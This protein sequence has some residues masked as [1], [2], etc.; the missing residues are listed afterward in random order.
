MLYDANQHTTKGVIRYQNGIIQLMRWY[1][2][3]NRANQ[4]C[5]VQV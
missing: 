3:I 4:T 5:E 1:L 2:G